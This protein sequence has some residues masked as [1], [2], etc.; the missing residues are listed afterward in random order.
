[1]N[2]QSKPLQEVV[3]FFL[4]LGL[5]AFGGPAAHIAIMHDEVVLRRNWLNDQHF[6]DLLGAAQLIPGP[7]STEMAIQIGFARAGW[8][9]LVAGG[10]CFILPAMLIVTALAWAYVQFGAMPQVNSILYAIKP[11]VIVIVAQ[12]LWELRKIIKTRW[13][14]VV[15]LAAAILF[16]LGVNALM[17]LIAG[18]VVVMSSS[19]LPRRPTAAL[20]NAPFAGIVAAAAP[21][22]AFGLP[23]LFLTLLKIGTVLYGSGYVLLAFLRQDFVQSLGWLTDQQLIDAVAIGQ[24]TPGPVFTTATF[25]GYVL[26]GIPGALVATLAIF[27]PAFVFVALVNPLLPRIRRSPSARALLDGVN[28]ASLGLMA[29]VMI[30][31]GAAALTDV[32]TIAIGVIAAVLLFRFRLNPTWLIGGGAAA[33]IAKAFL[34]L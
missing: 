20:V 21:A 6:A 2:D 3:R 25:I 9:G 17:L 34:N 11:I 30:Q 18:A 7:S 13:M 15:G 22:A 29:A 26:G 23:L 28:A 14:W 27:L 24:V 32:I 31:L 10:V 19:S 33:G 8:L 16:L 4:R 5:T 12:A 1:M